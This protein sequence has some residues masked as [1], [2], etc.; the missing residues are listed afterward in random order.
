MP[1][2]VCHVKHALALIVVYAV[3]WIFIW[4][5]TALTFDLIKISSKYQPAVQNHKHVSKQ[6]WPRKKNTSKKNNKIYDMKCVQSCR[7]CV[8]TLTNR[9]KV[10]VNVKPK[11]HFNK[12]IIITSY[13]DGFHIHTNKINSN[14]STDQCQNGILFILFTFYFSYSFCILL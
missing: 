13:D 9:Y 14:W 5:P 7:L 12:N 11:K 4:T 10:K 6:L 8:C 1:V 3:L 2:V